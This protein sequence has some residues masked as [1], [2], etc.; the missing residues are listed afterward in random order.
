MQRQFHALLSLSPLSR[1]RARARA[2]EE[3]SVESLDASGGL[4]APLLSG[5]NP[6]IQDLIAPIYRGI[7]RSPA[8]DVV[9]ASLRSLMYYSG[10]RKLALCAHPG[11]YF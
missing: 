11:V 5:D 9:R 10:F 1:V 3:S 8:D 6:A 7:A 2:T 4:K